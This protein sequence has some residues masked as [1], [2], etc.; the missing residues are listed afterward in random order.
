MATSLFTTPKMP[1]YRRVRVA[2]LGAGPAGL[3]LAV[4]LQTRGIQV[5]I[6]S[7][8]DHLQHVNAIKE[9]GHLTTSGAMQGSA[10]LVFT[11]DIAAAIAFSKTLILTVPS[12]G[13]ETIL[14]ELRH[15][16]LH[17]HTI[18]A[19]PGNL[20]SLVADLNVGCIV[21]TNLSPYSCRMN[22]NELKVLGKKDQIFA[23]T[24][25]RNPGRNLYDTI[26][27][28]LPVEICWC[29][30]V[31][32]V[33][34]LNINGVFHPLMM[35]LNAGRIESTDGDFF[36]YRDGLTPSVANAMVAVDT[37]RMQVGNAFGLY[38]KSALEVSNE[39]YGHNFTSLVDLGRNSG[40]HN[41]LKSPASLEH[42]NISEDVPDLLACWLSLAEKLGIDAAPIRAVIVL[43]HMTTGIDYLKAGRNLQ[44]LRLEEVGRE[45]LVD[46]FWAK[47]MVRSEVR[48][49]SFTPEDI[50]MGHL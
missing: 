16:L 49:D 29:S 21:E 43:V 15:F 4:D 10:K 24:S 45:E 20:F 9:K 34:L 1:L 50:V 3:A 8:A 19:I 37:V 38:L 47:K 40:P 6:Y 17:D 46:R 39:C 31:V 42:R 44:K 27:R 23:A 33:C 36:I 28:L 48:V 22:G 41:R 32:E 7:H 14:E 12:T 35:L 11:T 26:E 5:L 25:K 13:Q 2:I 18:I 30:S